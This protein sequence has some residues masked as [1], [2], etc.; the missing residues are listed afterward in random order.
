MSNRSCATRFRHSSSTFTRAVWISSLDGRDPVLACPPRCSSAAPVRSCGA[1]RAV[2]PKRGAGFPLPR[3][4]AWVVSMSLLSAV[5]AELN[6][7]TS[8][9]QLYELLMPYAGRV[10][11]FAAGLACWGSVSYHLGLLASTL[12]RV[13][14]AIRHYEDAATVHERMGA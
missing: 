13:A 2:R 10:G 3:D 12:G 8:A 11:I 1:K 9:A 6:D 14:D 7:R 5:A 4:G